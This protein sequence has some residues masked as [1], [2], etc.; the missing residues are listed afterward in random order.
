MPAAPVSVITTILVDI[1]IIFAAAKIAGELFERIRQPA[2]IGEILAGMLIGPFALGLIGQPG[3]ALV[4]AFHDEEVAREVLNTIYEVL[5]EVGVIVLLFVVGLE[6]HLD[7]FLSVGR[8]AAVVG[9]LGVV[10]PLLLGFGLISYLGYPQPAAVFV[11]TAMVATSVG[12]TARVL[13]DF[14]VLQEK[15]ASI[16]LAA[17]VVDDILGMILLASV[18]SIGANG[19]VSWG[20]IGLV[21][22][23]ALAFTGFTALVGARI[24]R[25]FDAHLDDLRLRNGP[26]VVA[27]SVCLGLAALAGYVGLAAIIGAFLAGMAFSQA[28]QRSSLLEQ[29]RPVYDF[30][31]PFFFVVTGAQVD[32]R[33]LAQPSVASLALAVTALA[34][35]GKLAGCSLGA[36]GMS[37]RSVAVVSIGMVPRGEVGLIVA[38]IGLSAQAL[39]PELF[40]VVVAMSILTTLIVPPT[41]NLIYRSQS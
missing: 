14:G 31:V 19:G 23:E 3:P 12:I 41:L 9:A 1:F 7:Q 22:A 18:V 40:S 38:A 25:R 39:S 34:V 6:V 10:L 4:S 2:V 11:G 32:L 13:A 17:A 26:F 15:E 16:I 5:A 36:L 35:I 33:L 30:L 8:R 37:W 20:Q 27:M 24:I 21:A 29:A 28:R